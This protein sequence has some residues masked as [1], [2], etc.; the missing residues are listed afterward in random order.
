MPDHLNPILGNPLQVYLE[1]ARG[2]LIGSAWP[3]NFVANPS[4][5]LLETFSQ[6]LEEFFTYLN[7]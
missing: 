3:D 6:A 1:D 2:V 4:V 7:L 5:S